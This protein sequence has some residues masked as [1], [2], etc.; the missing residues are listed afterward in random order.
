MRVT[1]L[2]VSF[3]AALAKQVREAAGD[4]PISASLADAAGRKLRA[5]GLLEVVR[6]WET[7]HRTL[8]AP[9]RKRRKA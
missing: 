8:D 6:E 5:E 7:R 9:K 2:A 4:E 3:D 1:R